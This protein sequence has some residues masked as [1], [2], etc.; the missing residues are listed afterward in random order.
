[1]LIAL[2]ISQD[3]S[4]L[5]Y[6]CYKWHSI[7][8]KKFGPA[9]EINN[10][11]QNRSEYMDATIEHVKFGYDL[12]GKNLTRDQQLAEKVGFYPLN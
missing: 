2:F 1:M 5:D 7:L 9:G 3:L 11:E 6:C 12:P 4:F 10:G 8:I